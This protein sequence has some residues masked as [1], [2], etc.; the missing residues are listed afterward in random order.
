MFA[1]HEHN[2]WSCM[3]DAYAA[4]SIACRVCVCVCGLAVNRC[5]PII[6]GTST[7]HPFCLLSLTGVAWPYW[8]VNYRTG[9]CVCV[10]AC[11]CMCDKC[12]CEMWIVKH[13][14]VEGDKLQL[15]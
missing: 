8:Q 15:T 2:P 3:A 10:C 1:I 11:V 13:V 14:I 12:A 5:E 7:N 4:R 6:H 9:R